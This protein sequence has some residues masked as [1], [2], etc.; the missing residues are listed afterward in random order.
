MVFERTVC[1]YLCVYCAWIH[2]MYVYI[3][4]IYTVLLLLSM[5]IPWLLPASTVHCSLSAWT[6]KYKLVCRKLILWNMH[7]HSCLTIYVLYKLDMDI[8]I[9]ILYIQ[10][11]QYWRLQYVHK[12]ST[13]TIAYT[14]HA[15]K[16]VMNM[17]VYLCII[18][19][20]IRVIYIMCAVTL[21]YPLHKLYIT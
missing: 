17:Y 5:G 18:L 7:P 11:L 9:I 8:I 6:N 21:Y 15:Y 10:M 4:T 19:M 2:A 16:T 14:M 3:C 20:C 12:H 13:C 1:M